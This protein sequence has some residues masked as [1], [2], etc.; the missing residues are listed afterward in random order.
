MITRQNNRID[1]DFDIYRKPINTDRCNP[2]KSYHQKRT[3]HA[4]FNSFCYRAVNVPLSED[5]FNKEIEK[6]N[7]IAKINGFD[8]KIIESL[9]KKHRNKKNLTN[10]TSLSFI[11]DNENETIYTGGVF[12][13]DLTTRI[14]KIYRKNNIKFSPNSTGYKLKT[15]FGNAKDKLENSEKSGIF[16]ILCGDCDD[17][18][19]GQCRRA[20]KYRFG[21]HYKHNQQG[22]IGKSTAADHFILK[23]HKF[24]GFRLLQEVRKPRYLRIC[25]FIKTGQI[26]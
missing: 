25:I 13:N 17:S 8:E 23:N 6:I 15:L 5:N 16:S 7:Q 4:A 14:S 20:I 26:V 1:F 9:M 22:E 3:K 24:A 11:S 18:Y 19:I 12:V 10:I 2:N 21:E